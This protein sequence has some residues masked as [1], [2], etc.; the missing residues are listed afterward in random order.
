MS[1]FLLLSFSLITLTVTALGCSEPA[2]N[3][4]ATSPDTPADSSPAIPTTPVADAPS[5]GDL[6]VQFADVEKIIQ[7]RCTAC[8]ADDPSIT[9]FG[10][11]AG[12]VLFET[13]QQMKDQASR[14]RA[15]AVNSKGMPT[16]NRTNMTDEERAILG[17]WI[18]EG[19]NIN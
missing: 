4:A 1:R 8:H 10:R 11:P 7:E 14:I 12:G 15:R 3:P 6:K 2:E 5:D 16:G 18:E 9:T 13:P 19:A 17:R